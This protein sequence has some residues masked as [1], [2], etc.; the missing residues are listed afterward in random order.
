MYGAVTL[1][2]VIPLSKL[3]QMLGMAVLQSL[4]MFWEVDFCPTEHWMLFLYTN[5]CNTSYT[6]WTNTTFG[7]AKFSSSIWLYLWPHLRVGNNTCYVVVHFCIVVHCSVADLLYTVCMLLFAT[8][9]FIELDWGTCAGPN[10][11]KCLLAVF[12]TH[13]LV[14]K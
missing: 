5:L 3:W 2:A 14:R 6:G 8:Q 9:F 11:M 13:Q 7:V 1:S 12:I 10:L 4:S